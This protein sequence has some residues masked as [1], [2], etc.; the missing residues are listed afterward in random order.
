[1]ETI[2]YRPANMVPGTNLPSR[3]EADAVLDTCDDPPGVLGEDRGLAGVD[4]ATVCVAKMLAPVS[5]ARP[6]VEQKRL[7]SAISLEQDGQVAMTASHNR[8]TGTG[9]RRGLRDS[10]CN[11]PLRKLAI[12]LDF[13]F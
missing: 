1:M 3:R 13:V 4:A 11:S 9:A 5:T 6:H 2:R 10:S 7:L 12:L 8:T